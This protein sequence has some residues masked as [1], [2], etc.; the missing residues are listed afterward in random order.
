MQSPLYVEQK[1]KLNYLSRIQFALILLTFC[2]VGL[3]SFIL[4]KEATHHRVLVLTD[5]LTGLENRTALFAELERHRRSCGS[6][7]ARSEWF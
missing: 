6:L 1:E 5:P 2:C 7:F 4:H 3:V